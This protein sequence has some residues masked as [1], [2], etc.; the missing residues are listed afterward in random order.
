M[1][2]QIQKG[3]PVLPASP[4][5]ISSISAIAHSK[6][7]VHSP[8]ATVAQAEADALFAHLNGQRVGVMIDGAN[9]YSTT[10]QLGFVTDYR[11]LRD[12]FLRNCASAEIHYF[13]AINYN[14]ENNNFIKTLTWMM[15]N[16]YIVSHKSAKS[17][18]QADGQYMLKGN[19][20]VELT[21]E[22]MG[23][24]PDVDHMVLFSGDGDF[25]RLVTKLQ[26]RGV[27]VTVISSDTYPA[28]RCADDLKAVSNVYIDIPE[29]QQAIATTPVH[30]DRHSDSHPDRTRRAV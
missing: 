12:L 18:R 26:E 10:R 24:A 6:G 7:R 4:S 23:L 5:V 29:F 22:A 21:T 20:D 17:L 3:R 15:N 25:C 1:H 11:K 27:K 2:T 13:T 16:G 14:S 8:S 9:F 19:M 30:L 28:K